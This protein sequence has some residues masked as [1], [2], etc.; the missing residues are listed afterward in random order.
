[1]SGTLCEGACDDSGKDGESKV[2]DVNHTMDL[3]DNPEVETVKE[4]SQ[5]I[6]DEEVYVPEYARR[7]DGSVADVTC[8]GE[9]ESNASSNLELPGVQLA[10]NSIDAYMSAKLPLGAFDDDIAVFESD[11]HEIPKMVKDETGRKEH[12]LEIDDASTP[13]ILNQMEMQPKELLNEMLSSTKQE[14]STSFGMIKD[15]SF[16]DAVHEVLEEEQQDLNASDDNK[17]GAMFLPEGMQQG[18]P[19]DFNEV[20]DERDARNGFKFSEFADGILDSQEKGVKKESWCQGS[21]EGDIEKKGLGEVAEFQEHE[22]KK[23]RSQSNRHKMHELDGK[24]VTPVWLETAQAKKGLAPITS[25]VSELLSTEQGTTMEGNKKLMEESEKLR[26]MME[27]LMKVG[28]E[29][30]N[31]IT[32]LAGRV[33]YLERKLARKKKMRTRRGRTGTSAPCIT[34]P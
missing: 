23:M 19:E 27:T 22:Y 10:G 29:Q 2:I 6:I 9:M 12:N 8:D 32:N 25:T 33:K 30:L 11:G 24:E 16:G 13:A 5:G 7:Q 34:K 20:Y 14:D 3:D 15:N 1:M 26:E 21:K 18:S 17:Q 31:V 4:L 28:K